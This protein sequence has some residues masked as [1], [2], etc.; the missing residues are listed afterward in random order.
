MKKGACMKKKRVGQVAVELMQTEAPTRDPIELQRAM[1][2]DY[3]ANLIECWQRGTREFPGDFFIIVETKKERLLPNVYRNYFYCRLSCP[4]PTYDQAVY[5]YVKQDDALEFIWV[6]PSKDT[7]T[8]LVDH[9]LEVVPE[10]RELLYFV[11]QFNDGTLLR[12]AK[13]LNGER[14]DSPL[15]ITN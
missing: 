6:L 10:E 13:E 8:V 1:Q 7:C 5:R 14:P 15:L 9:A 4:T 2:E 11:L 3:E 12:I